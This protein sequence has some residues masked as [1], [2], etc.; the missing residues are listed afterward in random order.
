MTRVVGVATCATLASL[1]WAAAALA[2][3]SRVL[4]V[5]DRSAD[6]VV[7][8]AEVRLAAELRAAGFE[9]DERV[10]DGDAEA[11]KLVEQPGDGGAFATVLLQRAAAG[12]S[13]D[14]WVADHVTHKTVLRRM[15]AH[16]RGDAADRSL[17][18]R[19]VELMRAS[20]VEALVLPAPTEPPEAAPPPPPPPPPLDVARW[21][22]EA[23]QAPPTALAPLRLSLGAAA[24]FG[25]SAVGMAVAPELRIAWRPSVAWSLGLLAAGPA[26]GARASGSEGSAEIRQE[27]ALVELAYELRVATPLRAFLAAG[28]GAY[29]LVASGNASSPFTSG[30]G[31]AWAALVGVGLGLEVDLVG[32]ASLVLDAH[33][34]FAAPQPVI[35][36]AA[37]H[38]A[39][40]MSP[41]TLLSLS[42]AVEL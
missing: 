37:D 14:V 13:T 17:A 33:E 11:R 30:Q 16:G 1:V 29:H 19:I 31:D 23:L 35:A 27:L 4:V 9:V 5:R 6:A 18:L 32:P 28:A 21:T 39:T 34:L 42:L 7:E 20:L 2:E 26:F 36:F 12:A 24:A 25:G 41:G 3:P 38:V 40:V 15:E 10:A 8:R 22:R